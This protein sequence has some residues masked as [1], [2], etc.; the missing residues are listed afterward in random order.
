MENAFL[1][2]IDQYP[3]LKNLHQKIIN[4]KEIT[5]SLSYTVIYL[6]HIKSS[7]KQKTLK[8][9]IYSIVFHNVIWNNQP[10]TVIIIE[11]FFLS[12]LIM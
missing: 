5:C 12:L 7:K 9:R 4:T 10:K 8:C 1:S 2:I 6:I 11:L 3:N